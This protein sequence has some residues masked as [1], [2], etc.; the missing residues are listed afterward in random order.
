MVIA[1]PVVGVAVDVAQVRSVQV[2]ELAIEL[3]L[4]FC[5]VHALEA[6]RVRPRVPFGLAVVRR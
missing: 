3:L 2:R 1:D 6:I 5:L 4:G